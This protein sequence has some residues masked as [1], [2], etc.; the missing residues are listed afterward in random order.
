[1][2]LFGEA[3]HHALPLDLDGED[4]QPHREKEQDGNR[5]RLKNLARGAPAR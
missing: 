5:D 4:E 1:V 2:L 3:R